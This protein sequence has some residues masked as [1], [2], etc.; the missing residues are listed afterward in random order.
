MSTLSVGNSS[1]N[2]ATPN[3][4][5]IMDCPNEIIALICRYLRDN[6]TIQLAM[7]NRKLYSLVSNSQLFSSLWDLFLRQ[8]FPDSYTALKPEIEKTFV[9][10][11]HLTNAVHNMKAGIYRLQTLQETQVNDFVICDNKLVSASKWI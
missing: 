6:G 4:L 1:F 3:T 2:Y 8:R 7:T 9:L 10:F 11:K 5:S